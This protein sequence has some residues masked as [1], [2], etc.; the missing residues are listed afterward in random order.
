MDDETLEIYSTWWFLGSIWWNTRY[1]EEYE[2]SY[3]VLNTNEEL[4]IM[5]VALVTME[6]KFVEAY[7][8][9]FS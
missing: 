2:T 7:A 9:I 8:N 3:T 5:D 4:G 6:K 1:L